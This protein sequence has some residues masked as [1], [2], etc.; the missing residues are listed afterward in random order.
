MDR[1]NMPIYELL[2]RMT[3]AG[4]RYSQPRLT[5][6]PRHTFLWYDGQKLYRPENL[7][8]SQ[9]RSKD[10]FVSATGMF[11]IAFPWATHAEE[12]AERDYLKELDSTSQDEIAGNVWVAPQFGTTLRS[13]PDSSEADETMQH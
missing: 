10:G 11:K 8:W 6:R 2:C 5:L 4:P 9:R 12:K 1:S 3:L 13:A 7:T